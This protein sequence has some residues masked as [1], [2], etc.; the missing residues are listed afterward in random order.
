MRRLIAVTTCH[1]YEYFD[2]GA[3]HKNGP[4]K[5]R[6]SAIRNT[7]FKQWQEDFKDQIDLKFFYGWG[8]E[9]CPDVDEVFLDC[10]D[11][12]SHLPGKVQKIFDWSLHN[13]YEQV[14]KIDDDVFLYVDRLVDN[15]GFDDYRGYE[16]EAAIGKYASGTAYWISKRSMEIVVAS[17]LPADE[18]AEDKAVGLLLSRNGVKLT[19]DDRFHCCHCDHCLIA[20]PQSKRISSHTVNPKGM[21]E[22]WMTSFSAQSNYPTRK[23]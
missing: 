3:G 22:L 11:D 19:H 9:R 21:E 4:N 1:N 6:A 13:G 20:T 23:M 14:L 7:W 17:E 2:A 12:Y 15:F 5:E 16:V 8:A 18:W 10:P